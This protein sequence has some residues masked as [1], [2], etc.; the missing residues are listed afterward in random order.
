MLGLRSIITWLLPELPNW[1]AADVA[2]GEHC[3]GQMQSKGETLRMRSPPIPS[4]TS[5]SAEQRAPISIEM[6]TDESTTTNEQSLASQG[7][8][9]SV[10]NAMPSTIP[11]VEDSTTD[12]TRQFHFT[13]KRES[14]DESQL[15]QVNGLCFEIRVINK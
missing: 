2:L 10:T 7:E 9:E 6:D 5:T 4:S 1:L 12:D 8:P 3:H 11:H 13:P 14:S 15:S